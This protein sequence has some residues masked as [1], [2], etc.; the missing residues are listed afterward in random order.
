MA[1]LQEIIGQVQ[2]YLHCQ[3]CGRKFNLGEIKLRGFFDSTYFFQ[4]SCE[5]GHL[6]LMM[7]FIA[8]LPTKKVRFSGAKKIDYD[9]VIDAAGVIDSFHGEFSDIFRK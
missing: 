8:T 9:E 1:H 3:I 7:V 5:N 4:A 6:P 2:R